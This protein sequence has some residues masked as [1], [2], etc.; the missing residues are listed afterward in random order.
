MK[1]RYVVGFMFNENE[2]DV[3]LIQ[4]IKPMWQFGKMNGIGGKVEKHETFGRAMCREFQEETGIS[5]GDWDYV[6]TMLGEDWEVQVFKAKTDDVFSF[7]QMEF[8]EPHLI[9]L[10]ELDKYDLIPNLYWLIPMC[11][12]NKI[13]YSVSNLLSDNL[14]IKQ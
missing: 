14:T 6:T 12:D 13:N 10:S 11:L 8:E 3:L 9:P 1:T 2:T 5:W 7:K 4:K